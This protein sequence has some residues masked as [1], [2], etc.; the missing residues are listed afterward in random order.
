M[1]RGESS[2]IRA[3]ASS[4]ASGSPSRRTHNSA[5]RV[6]V[7]LG[8][9]EVGP[10]VARASDEEPY[11]LA[12]PETVDLERE[13]RVGKRKRGDGVD[14]LLGDVERGAAGD[15]ETQAGCTREQLGEHRRRTEHLLEVVEHEQRPPAAQRC[16]QRLE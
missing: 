15:E 3:A 6:G 16:D 8:E 14:P 1:S 5:D 11:R 9:L 10:C 4:S 12:A 7:Q 2:L 13:R